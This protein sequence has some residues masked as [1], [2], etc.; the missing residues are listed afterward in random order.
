MLELSFDSLLLCVELVVMILYLWFFW[1]YN[2]SCCRNARDEVSPTVAI[3]KKMAQIGNASF[4]HSLDEV[5]L[6]WRFQDLTTSLKPNVAALIWWWFFSILTGRN[7]N[8]NV[9]IKKWLNLHWD[10]RWLCFYL[11]SFQEHT[12]SC[13]FCY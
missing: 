13:G 5:Q 3:L 2:N 8:D 6:T 12:T 10:V 1:Q 7:C 9:L 11:W 4:Q